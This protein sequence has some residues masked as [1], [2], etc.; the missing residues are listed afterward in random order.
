MPETA[1][2]WSDVI[3]IANGRWPST[4]NT[5]AEAA[6][7]DAFVKVYLR[8]PDRSDSF[9]DAAVVVIAYGLRPAA[10]NTDSEK[11]AIKSFKHIYGYNPSGA[12]DW[13]VVRAIAYS[14][15]TRQPDA[16]KDLLSDAYEAILGTDPNKFDTDND[17]YSD[18]EEIKNGHNP[19]G[20]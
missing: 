19:L 8:L 9:D 1:D 17:G 5:E 3:K 16:D 13:D 6:A 15:A 14:G 12:I 7:T 11:A 2:D 10:R 4:A 20:E 18:G